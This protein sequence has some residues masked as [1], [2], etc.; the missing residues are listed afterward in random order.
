M[1]LA[2]FQLELY[3]EI[4]KYQE[5]LPIVWS[6]CDLEDRKCVEKDLSLAR[7]APLNEKMYS[8]RQQAA[9]CWKGHRSWLVDH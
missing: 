8:V 5:F 6:C 1:K 7:L 2:R 9:E 3:S 4:L